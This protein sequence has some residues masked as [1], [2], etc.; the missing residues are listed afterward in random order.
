MKKKSRLDYLKHFPYVLHT[1]GKTAE[2]GS[3]RVKKY[4][5]KMACKGTFGLRP[6]FFKNLSKLF[7]KKIGRFQ[8]IT[9]SQ[10]VN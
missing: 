6:S 8:K 10:K 1:L 3:L 5:P 7:L 2:C 9:R 4:K